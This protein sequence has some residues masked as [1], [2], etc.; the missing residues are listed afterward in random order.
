[1]QCSFCGDGISYP[2]KFGRAFLDQ[3]PIDD[4]LTEWQPTWAKP[5]FYDNYFEYNNIKYILEMDGGFH[6]NDNNGFGQSLETRQ[7]IDSVKND[8]AQ[9]HDIVVVR[10]DCR[11]SNCDYIKTSILNSVLYDIFELDLI[12]WDLCNMKAQKSLVKVACDLYMSGIKST[13]EISR[14]IKVSTNAI[15][16]YLKTGQ[17]FGW[18]DY[19][20]KKI[21]STIQN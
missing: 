21:N 2:N 5:Y 6:Y 14:K 12:D 7:M 9:S 8:L 20:P 11:E 1:L 4:Y 3:L 16:K 17:S 19:I 13:K 18:C 15:I 10:I